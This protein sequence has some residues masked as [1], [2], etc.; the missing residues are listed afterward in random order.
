MRAPR[1]KQAFARTLRQSLSPP[2]TRLW[3]RLRVRGP[4]RPSFRRQHPIGPY[5]A[6]FFCAAA[7]LVVEV[8]GSQHAEASGKAH[9]QRRDRYLESLGYAVLRVWASEVMANPDG[10]AEWVIARALE[11]SRTG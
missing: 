5:V 8:D 4:E 3:V 9:D 7:K 2:E 1:D 11:R 6:D 10:V